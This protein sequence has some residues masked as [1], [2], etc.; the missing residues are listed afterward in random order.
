MHVFPPPHHEQDVTQGQFL[1]WVQLIRIQSF[2]SP[3][4]VGIPR[5]KSSVC[6]LFSIIDKNIVVLNLFH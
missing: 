4:L 2:P 5:F 3:R 1:S 6:I